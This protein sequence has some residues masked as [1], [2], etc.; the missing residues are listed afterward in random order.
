ME[1]IIPLLLL[2]MFCFSAVLYA[3]TDG[4]SKTYKVGNAEFISIKDKDNDMAK[5]IFLNQNAAAVKRLMP[6]NSYPASIN[7]FILKINGKIILFDAGL[8]SASGGAAVENIKKYGIDPKKIDIVYLTHMH[9]DHVGGL[10][11]NGKKTFPNAVIYVSKD[12][13]DYWI[14]PDNPR[15]ALSESAKKIQKEYGRNLKTF[16]WGAQSAVAE[17]TII[18]AIG[19]TPGHSAYQIDLGGEKIL[20]VGDIIHNLLVQ[21]S[22]PS[23]STR[24]DVDPA[25]AAKTRREL[26]DYAA[27]NKIKI[28]GMHIPFSGLGMPKIKG[29]KDAFDFIK[30]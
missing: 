1:K 7:V 21:I 8:G 12:E 19:H 24:Y 27:K 14:S 11:E 10:L 26:L 25:Q 30:E 15:P 22:D 20:V 9:A 5:S 28:A 17:I 2:S 29:G 18:K 3:D 16:L 6:G 4:Q 13:L 23:L